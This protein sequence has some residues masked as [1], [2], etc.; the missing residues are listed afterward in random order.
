MPLA[1]SRQPWE[2]LLYAV[3]LA[4]A[5]ATLLYQGDTGPGNG[6]SLGPLAFPRYTA[7]LLL[8][9]LFI[10]LVQCRANARQGNRQEDPAPA[11]GR[12][13][14][15]GML[16]LILGFIALVSLQWLPFWVCIALFLIASIGFLNTSRGW[17][18]MLPVAVFAVA[19]AL[20]ISYLVQTVFYF[21][22]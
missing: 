3:V 7:G 13:K 9:L 18:E 11:A 17:R 22:L 15:F 8:G 5:I 4:L 20:S 16:L 2:W 19:F 21:S 10:K 1:Q 6:E 12:A 14:V